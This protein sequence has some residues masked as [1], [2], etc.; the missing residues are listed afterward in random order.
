MDV[1]HSKMGHGSNLVVWLGANPKQ[2]NRIH[3]FYKLKPGLRNKEW[4]GLET[5]TRYWSH[6]PT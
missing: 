5:P 2:K 1:I 3:L 6:S 4:G